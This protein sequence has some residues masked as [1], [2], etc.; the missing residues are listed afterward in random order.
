MVGFN[1]SI[2]RIN[3]CSAEFGATDS[4]QF[5]PVDCLCFGGDIGDV[6]VVGGEQNSTRFLPWQFVLFTVFKMLFGAE[7][8]FFSF[9][10]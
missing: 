5:Y 1:F 9:R 6:M 10:K 3:P 4:C 7:I 8:K 2:R